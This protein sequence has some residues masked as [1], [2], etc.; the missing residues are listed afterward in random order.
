MQPNFVDK[1][2]SIDIFKGFYLL[3]NYSSYTNSVTY[4]IIFM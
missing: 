4:S 2:V 3:Y 1:A